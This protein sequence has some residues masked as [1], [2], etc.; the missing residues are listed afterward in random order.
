MHSCS[1][2]S[3]PFG[4]TSLAICCLV[5]MQVLETM[6]AAAIRSSLAKGLVSTAADVDCHPLLL[7]QNAQNT[8]TIATHH[9]QVCVPPSCLH[10]C[11]SNEMNDHSPQPLRSVP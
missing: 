6:T 11:W 3:V 7:A 8:R 4:L 5:V 2:S 9:E 10:I 1:H